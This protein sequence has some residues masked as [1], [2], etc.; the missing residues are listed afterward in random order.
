MKEK[1]MLKIMYEQNHRSQA[2]D[3][4]ADE[5]LSANL[6]RGAR[7]KSR[8]FAG[9]IAVL[10]VLAVA[11]GFGI[12][13]LGGSGIETASSA[14][15]EPVATTTS[16]YLPDTDLMDEGET[17]KAATTTKP[18]IT[19]EIYDDSTSEEPVNTT[20]SWTPDMSYSP[21]DI[22]PIAGEVNLT[23]GEDNAVV[24]F[25][26]S[27]NH[28]FPQADMKFWLIE[29]QVDMLK[30][31]YEAYK[32]GEITADTLTLENDPSQFSGGTWLSVSFLNKDGEIIYLEGIDVN[33]KKAYV[34]LIDGADDCATGNVFYFSPDNQMYMALWKIWDFYY[35]TYEGTDS[36]PAVT[37]AV[38]IPDK[39]A[40]TTRKTT[41]KSTDNIHPVV[42]TGTIDNETAYQIALDDIGLTKD[43]VEYYNVEYCYNRGAFV[44]AVSINAKNTETPYE[45]TL[46][47]SGNIISYEIDKENNS[48]AFID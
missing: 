40:Q 22:K 35:D 12:Y 28:D 15:S 33:E 44:Y 26:R 18:L 23:L 30:G 24:H 10:A 29:E 17:P 45:F 8:G 34:R 39:G 11:V 37:K 9:A 6:G 16:A 42:R 31:V 14:A 43:D 5:I 4:S 47:I 3:M 48:A 21:E 25:T 36:L 1:D 41:A 38:E 13:T 19:G 7:V 2:L 27:I 46:D 20:V 32:S